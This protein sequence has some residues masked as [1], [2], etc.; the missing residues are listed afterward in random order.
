MGATPTHRVLVLIYLATSTS[1]LSGAVVPASTLIIDEVTTL[2]SNESSTTPAL[3]VEQLNDDE[4]K[5][6][7]VV[8]E[9][10]PSESTDVK[11][12]GDIIEITPNKDADSQIETV[13]EEPVQPQMDEIETTT[14]G[15]PSSTSSIPSTTKPPPPK[16]FSARERQALIGHLNGNYDQATLVLTEN[17]KL[18]IQQENRIRGQGFRAFSSP[19]AQSGPSSSPD[20][21]RSIQNF[22]PQQS[23]QQFG[24]V[25]QQQFGSVQQQ[26][27]GSPQQQQFGSPQQQQFGSPQ[28]QQFGSPQQQQFGSPQQERFGSPL[29]KPFG[30]PQQQQ[31][32]SPQQERFGS[33]L[34]QQFGP[35]QQQT[36]GFQ[37]QPQLGLQQQQPAF[38]PIQQQQQEGINQIPPQFQQPG[39]QQL[40]QQRPQF[41]SNPREGIATPDQQAEALKQSLF[42]ALQSS[43]SF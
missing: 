18:A 35:P 12:K 1:L 33:P 42:S 25:Q 32:G 20:Q 17:Q 39:S 8:V 5:E 41:P 10:L 43:N 24:S 23:Q 30:S 34:Q 16:V 7:A 14:L 38:N 2:S 13:E 40:F 37:Q 19:F 4:T 29:Q 15:L 26:Q 28:Q 6:D 36:F 21:P 11:G 27:F 9:N 3:E 22:S 31:F